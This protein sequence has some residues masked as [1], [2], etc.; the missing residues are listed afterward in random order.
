MGVGTNCIEQRRRLVTVIFVVVLS[1]SCTTRGS[2]I[3]KSYALAIGGD[4][5]RGVQ[6]IQRAGCGS[7]HVIP[8]VA[9]AHGLAAAPLLWFSRRTFIAGE[10]PNTPDNLVRWILSPQGIEPH[11]A[12]PNVGLS[13]QQARDVA[14]Y[15]FTLR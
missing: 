11:T 14:A 3:D 7:C 6:T 10:V 4:P 2:D 1:A 9:G 13:D 8:G 15:L 5:A 12:M